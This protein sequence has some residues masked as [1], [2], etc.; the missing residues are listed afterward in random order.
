MTLPGSKK[1]VGNY[2]FT[3]KVLGKGNFA[4]VEEAIHIIL[5]TKVAVK[6]MDVNEIREDY[7]IKNLY[8]EGKILLKLN[9]PCIVSLYETMQTSNNVYYLVTELVS[10]GDLCSFVKNQRTGRLEELPTRNFARQF[11]SAIGHMHSLGVVH[12]D[13]KMENVMLDAKQTQIKIVDFGLSNIFNQ[14]ISLQTHCGSPEYAAPELF[15]NGSHYG[16]EVDLWSL[17]RVFIYLY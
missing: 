2:R 1:K 13:L 14:N 10:G 6:I 8:R 4:K 15:V 7:V 16:P 17:G 9:H 11:A 3:G 5:N 12:R